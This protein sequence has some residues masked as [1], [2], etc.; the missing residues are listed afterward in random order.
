MSLHH[1]T[2]CFHADAR[3]PILNQHIAHC[4]ALVWL[5]HRIPTIDFYVVNVHYNVIRISEPGCGIC[6]DMEHPPL[7]FLRRTPPPKF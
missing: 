2:S 3:R 6:P 7:R 5:T 1:V 4:N